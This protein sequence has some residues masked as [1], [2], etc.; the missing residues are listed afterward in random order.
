MSYRHG[1]VGRRQAFQVHARAKKKSFHQ[2]H[3][4]TPAGWSSPVARQ[5]HN[6]K[7][8]S[9]NLVPAT[10]HDTTNQ[11][12]RLGSLQGGRVAFYGDRAA[13]GVPVDLTAAEMPGADSA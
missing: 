2:T 10:K 1:R 13:F 7:V 3:N 5:A 8:I 11:Y 4:H 9:S 6:L 12:A